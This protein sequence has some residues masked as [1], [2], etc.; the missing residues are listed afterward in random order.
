MNCCV[1]GTYNDT[2]DAACE[3]FTGKVYRDSCNGF[4]ACYKANI[5]IVHGCAGKRACRNSN[6]PSVMNSCFGPDACLRVGYNGTVGELV[7]SCNGTDACRRLGSSKGRDPK[8]RAGNL[9]VACHG[10]F[11]CS[12]NRNHA[13][14]YFKVLQCQ[15]GLFPAGSRFLCNGKLL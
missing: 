7:N 4:S 15:Q 6:I 8:N 10:E 14:G 2:Y 11:A 9:Y 12:Y 13:Y 3:G 1:G 5:P